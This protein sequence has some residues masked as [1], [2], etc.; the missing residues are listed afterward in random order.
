MTTEIQNGFGKENGFHLPPE[1]YSKLNE[2]ETKKFRIFASCA[3]EEIVIS[4]ISGRFPS[5]DNVDEFS[6]NLYNKVSTSKTAV[7]GV[8]KSAKLNYSNR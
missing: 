1:N 8:I 3:D 2:S 7:Y 6:K 4:G 5:S